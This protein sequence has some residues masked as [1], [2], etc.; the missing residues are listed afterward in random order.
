M[1][2]NL[3]KNYWEVQPPFKGNG[4]PGSLEW[5]QSI[6]EHRFQVAPYLKK[7]IDADAYKGKSILEIGYGSGSDL[8]EFCRAGAYVTGVDITDKAKDVCSSRLKAEKLHADLVTYDGLRLPKSL[9]YSSFDLVYS[10]GVLHHTPHM[11]NI[12][13]DAHNL[14]APSGHLKLMLYHRNSVLYHHILYRCATG[15]PV[16]IKCS[17]DDLLSLYSEYRE[18]C[19]Y[20]RVFSE[21]EI[22][23]RLWYY[24]AVDTS[25]ELPVYDDGPNRK[26]PIGEPHIIGLTGIID[27]DLF[28]KKYNEDVEAGVDLTKYGWHLLVDAKK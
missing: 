4:T 28:S 6:S 5:S 26:I 25:V 23:D 21:A 1:D 17:R 3:I 2:T 13:A 24:S 18:G 14:L 11:E 15:E 7:F 20:T 27:I 8:L 19:P 12:F 10:Y 22:K 9:D 16:L